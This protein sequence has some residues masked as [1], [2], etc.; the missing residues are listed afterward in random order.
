MSEDVKVSFAGERKPAYAD[1]YREVGDFWLTQRLLAAA[2]GLSSLVTLDPGIRGGV[3]VLRG[4]R[5]PL[6][7]LL[8]EIADGRSLNEIAEDHEL[9]L[10]AVTELLSALAS[11]LEGPLIQ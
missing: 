3:P 7:R 2:Q 6:A 10:D 5:F 4:T 8:A 1:A 11:S 9:P